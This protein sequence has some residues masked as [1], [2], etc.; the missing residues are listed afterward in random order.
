MKTT[1]QQ[2]KVF[3]RIGGIA[4]FLALLTMLAEIFLTFLPDGA[5]EIH[6]IAELM[7]MYQRNWFMAMRYMGLINIIATCFLI[8]VYYALY[9][10]HREQLPVFSGFAL[11]LIVLSY[12][13]FFAGNVSFPLL[14]LADKY[15]V[16]SES[17]KVFLLSAG[18]ALFVKGASHTPGTFPGFFTGQIAS[19][20]FSVIIIKGKI[21]KRYIGIIGVI[22]S[23]FLIVFEITSSFISSLYHEAMIFAMI[24]GLISLVW[25]VLIGI[26]L[27]R[28]HALRD[29]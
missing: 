6:S 9:G 16:A 27:L 29:A 21:F 8:P 15:S 19:I 3:Y 24:G 28:T 22:A 26:G 12:A 10:L 25:F 2:W 20:C 18:E 5:R 4:V 7:D 11:L 13:I 23:S 14:E 1:E 17:E